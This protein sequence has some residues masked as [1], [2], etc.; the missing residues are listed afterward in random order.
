LRL[1]N[2]Q[3]DMFATLKRVTLGPFYFE[4]TEFDMRE[5]LLVLDCELA[6]SE[7]RLQGSGL[8]PE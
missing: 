2:N 3:N 4:D 1:A 8:L 6:N 5:R 7:L